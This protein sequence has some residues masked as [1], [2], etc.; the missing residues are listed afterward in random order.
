M[1]ASE[2]VSDPAGGEWP[3]A[4]RIILEET[5][6]QKTWEPGKNKHMIMGPTGPETKNDC[7]GED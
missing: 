5:P 3:V 2:R 1:H 6:F 7:A 4:V